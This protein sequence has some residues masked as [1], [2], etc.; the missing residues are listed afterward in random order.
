MFDHL[1]ASV[2]TRKFGM[3]IRLPL[4]ILSNWLI[5]VV[6]IISNV[7]IRWNKESVFMHNYITI[8]I[9]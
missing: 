7:N 3:L 9:L 6:Y 5:T 8:D 2:K 1:R 4:I